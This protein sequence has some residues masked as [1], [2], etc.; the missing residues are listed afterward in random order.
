MTEVDGT[1]TIATVTGDI[2][3]TITGESDLT[4]QVTEYVKLDGKSVFLI[5]ANQTLAAG[6]AL[7]YDGTVMFYSNQYNAWCYLVI[8]DT[9][10]TVADAKAKITSGAVAFTTLEQT[11]DVNGAGEVDI[12]DAQLVFDMYNNEYQDFTVVTMQKF[13]NADVNGDKKIDVNDAAA[14][15]AAIIDAD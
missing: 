2:V 7:S 6:D 12:N 4:V 13:L 8:T 1:Y 9:T 10:L 3:I 11:Y 15:V 5:T 14:I